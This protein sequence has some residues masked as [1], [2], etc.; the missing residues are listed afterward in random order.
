MPPEPQPSDHG[1]EF[2][3]PNIV[4]SFG[5]IEGFREITDITKSA[6]SLAGTTLSDIVHN[7]H[8]AHLFFGPLCLAKTPLNS[9][10]IYCDIYHII[11]ILV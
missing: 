1:Q 5:R 11:F 3:V 6:N 10:V 8:L 7:C 4:V 2:P 9:E